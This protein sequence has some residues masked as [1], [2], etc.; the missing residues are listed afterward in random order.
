M[1]TVFTRSWWTENPCWPNG[2]EPE[3]GKKRV[4]RRDLTEDEAR[5][6][7]RE[8]NDPDHLKLL[9]GKNRLSIKAEFE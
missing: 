5:A 2:L 8:Y 7:C 4:L 9:Y 6:F 3:P 1:A